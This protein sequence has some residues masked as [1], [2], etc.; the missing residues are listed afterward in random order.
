M[1]INQ[2][3]AFSG[4]VV[5][6]LTF[7]LI[8]LKKTSSLKKQLGSEA[9]FVLTGYLM[10]GL[11]SYII[12]RLNPLPYER[13]ALTAD[14]LGK[15]SYLVKLNYL[16]IVW[17]G[18]YPNWLVGLHITVLLGSVAFVVGR[19]PQMG[20][21]FQQALLSVFFLMT[22]FV[23]PY[24]A[25]LL[26]SENWPTWRV[27]YL[28]PFLMAGTWNLLDQAISI[29]KVGLFDSVGLLSLILV[30]Y[31]G[32]AQVNASEYVKVFEADLHMLRQM[33]NY[34]I[35]Q[36]IVGAQVFVAIWPDFDRGSNPYGV[37][38]MFGFSKLSAFLVN[39]SNYS[40]IRRF[41]W[42]KPTEDTAV[43]KEC[44]TQCEL[45][46]EGKVFQFFKLQNSG[47]LCVCP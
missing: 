3:A 38:Y 46:K 28:A 27:M 8:S 25:V 20:W 44:L 9:I 22:A 15:L 19:A 29:N 33:E 16:F 47:A 11:L 37:K 39:W 45:T 36:H 10:G 35:Q 42:L 18:Y 26:V 23:A 31:I 13:I 2:S 6:L 14:Y 40:F 34:V 41:S 24:I 7:S 32:I 12:A 43:K 5:W 1:L 30:G 17:P 21:S 4:L